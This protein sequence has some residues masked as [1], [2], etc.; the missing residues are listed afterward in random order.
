MVEEKKPFQ[1]TQKDTQELYPR[2]KKKNKI[3]HFP[4][5][6]EGIDVYLENCENSDW[7]IRLENMSKIA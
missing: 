5:E 3:T 4:E 7:K 6:F 1:S 2:K